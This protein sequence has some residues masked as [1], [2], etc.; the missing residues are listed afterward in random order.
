MINYI[1]IFA[2]LITLAIVNLYLFKLITDQ[3]KDS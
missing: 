3:K 2:L 1:S